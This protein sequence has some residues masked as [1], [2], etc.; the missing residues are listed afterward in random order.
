[1]GE[2]A[3]RPLEQYDALAEANSRRSN[4]Q[5]LPS[6]TPRQLVHPSHFHIEIGNRMSVQE[7]DYD[8]WS[9]DRFRDVFINFFEFMDLSN[10]AKCA[11]VSRSWRDACYDPYLWR[12]LDLSRIRLKV[13]DGLVI[14]LL[15]SARFQMIESLSLEG[16]S[17]I[18]D[19]SL[20]LI[21]KLESLQSVKLSG[22]NRISEQAVMS[23]TDCLDL[24][25]LDLDDCEIDVMV[26]EILAK[27]RPKMDT[28]VLWRRYCALTGKEGYPSGCTD[29]KC[30]WIGGF[31]GRGCWGP[32]RGMLIHSNQGDYRRRGLKFGN[33][34][35]EVL[36]ACTSHATAN[37]SDTTI[38]TCLCCLKLFRR[39]SMCIEQSVCKVCHDAEALL[40]GKKWVNLEAKGW[41]DSITFGSVLDKTISMADMKNLPETLRSYGPSRF[42]PPMTPTAD[43]QE[44]KIDGKQEDLM[45]DGDRK[46]GEVRLIDPE[47]NLQDTPSEQQEQDYV[48]AWSDDDVDV[49]VDV[50]N[51]VLD[52]NP[53]NTSR[54]PSPTPN[55]NR[56][57]KTSFLDRKLPTPVGFDLQGLETKMPRAEGPQE[58]ALRNYAAA[59]AWEGAGRAVE[60]EGLAGTESDG[61][62][63]LGEPEEAAGTG[64]PAPRQIERLMDNLQN[65]CNAGETRA[66][67]CYDR[68]RLEIDVFADQQPILDGHSQHEQIV[69]TQRMLRQ[70]L[71]VLYPFV[72]VILIVAYFKTAYDAQ[73]RPPEK[74][75]INNQVSERTRHAQDTELIL[76]LAAVFFVIVIAIIWMVYRFRA[77]CE[78]IFRRFLVVDILMIY[79]F[80]GSSMI[81]ISLVRLQILV[82]VDTFALLSWNLAC[83][84]LASLYLKVPESLRRIY[85]VILSA[86]MSVMM[87]ITLPWIFLV[88]LLSLASL[89]DFSSSFHRRMRIFGEFI[90]HDRDIIPFVTPRIFYEVPGLR[91]R[92]ANL[93]TYG[94]LVGCCP[95]GT[96]VMTS[97]LV[98]AVGGLV[99]S[100]YILPYFQFKVR[101]LPLSMAGLV[102]FAYA[103]YSMIRPYARAMN[104]TFQFG[105]VSSWV[106]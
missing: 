23:L 11:A 28:G 30:R 3:S 99:F 2:Q 87:V 13:G 68:K 63:L 67:L 25:K 95:V 90:T 104:T 85:L 20:R 79:L 81:L 69:L 44:G 4:A 41:R 101:P 40:E 78:R 76:I 93:F 46:I 29:A 18:S 52:E 1:M 36:Y 38:F 75:A 49:D 65:A 96:S 6:T 59:E 97:A 55:S 80:G 21:S 71:F 105:G 89:I 61:D 31:G 43:D 88:I 48:N 5:S 7:M 27:L 98:C 14:R 19:N 92:F 33:Y 54:K 83:G 74:H 84:G 39:P 37:A 35:S 103:H 51:N 94:L 34:P 24:K 58:V 42:R 9:A 60:N 10:R 73:R 57:R 72:A 70:F 50:D 8:L 26:A 45:F 16:C 102:F 106:T 91:F 82:G 53:T 32:V 64:L 15:S 17:A 100:L 22:C 56:D 86:I 77:T 66:L 62:R 12:S 47:D